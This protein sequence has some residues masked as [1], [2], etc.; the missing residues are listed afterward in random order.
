M[1]T[2][3]KI[4]KLIEFAAFINISISYVIDFICLFYDTRNSDFMILSLEECNI[5]AKQY[6]FSLTDIK[7]CFW[8]KKSWPDLI[9]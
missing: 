5:I 8:D 1:V 7:Y 3:E 4:I 6:Q 9:I 2:K